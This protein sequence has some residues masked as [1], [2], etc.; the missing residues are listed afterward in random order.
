[1]SAATPAAALTA[2]RFI[3]RH[4][5]MRFLGDFEPAEGVVARRGDQVVL[6]TDRGLEIGQV[7]C[8]ANP[9]ALELLSEPTKGRILR[10]LSDADRAE[11]ERLRQAERRELETCLRFV[12]Q[13]KLQMELVDVE[14]LFGGERIIFYF[15]AE[16]RVDF[17]EL[18]KDLA[19][20]YQ[21]R[22]EMR[23]IGVRDEAKLLADYGDC[24]KPVCCNTHMVT[25][26][27]VS[28][29]MAKLQK[30]TLDPSKISGRCGRLKCCLRFEQ[31]VYEEF[32]KQL[33][34]VGARILTRK[35]QGRV[36]AQEVLARKV[37]VEFEDHRRLLVAA[38][39][40]LTQLGRGQGPAGRGA[41]SGGKPPPDRP[42]PD[43]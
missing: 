15:L 30:S 8:P 19:R 6:R 37:L 23:Q 24:G 17:R 13:R 3:V 35:G 41:E 12:G 28:M 11:R 29:R 42:P 16:K 39:E 22:I 32:Q 9:R 14:H 36:L 31:D 20:E 33:P 2:T 38:D 10:L 26:P 5:A 40:I 1:M 18:V 4:G 34:P 27:P 43:A 7:L 25:M 21:T